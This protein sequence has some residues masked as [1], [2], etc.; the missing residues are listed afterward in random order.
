MS[1]S[2]CQYVDNVD[3]KG[4]KV[5]IEPFLSKD[6]NYEKFHEIMDSLHDAGVKEK[7]DSD[8]LVIVRPMW[9]DVS[10]YLTMRYSVVTLV[11]NEARFGRCIPIQSVVLR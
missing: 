6:I 2:L 9:S 1:E 5:A 7:D 11:S 3:E 10:A 4:L 8:R